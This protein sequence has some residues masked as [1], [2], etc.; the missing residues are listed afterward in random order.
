MK[1][2]SN[3]TNRCRNEDQRKGERRLDA[4][5]SNG[6]S[7]LPDQNQA[8]EKEEDDDDDDGAREDDTASVY[9]LPILCFTHHSPA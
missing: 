8:R 7:R 6:V 9:L 5:Q 1:S 4:Y 2:K 3:S